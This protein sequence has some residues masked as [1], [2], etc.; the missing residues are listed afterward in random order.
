MSQTNIITIIIQHKNYNN[1]ES[2]NENETHNTLQIYIPRV[3][4]ID[5][6]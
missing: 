1:N 6:N 5:N 3:D 4:E 2:N